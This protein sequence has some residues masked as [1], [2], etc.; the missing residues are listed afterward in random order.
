MCLDSWGGEEVNS[1]PYTTLFRSM[2]PNS[3][4]V[5]VGLVALA[6]TWKPVPL[7]EKTAPR[8]ELA[9]KKLAGRLFG[10]EQVSA[11]ATQLTR[12]RPVPWVPPTPLLAPR[13]S[14]RNWCTA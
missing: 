8:G 11:T 1:L 10:A 5:L 4:G 12:R 2:F 9:L 7:V 6:L 3:T 13:R 14:A